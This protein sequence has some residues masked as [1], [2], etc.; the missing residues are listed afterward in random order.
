MQPVQNFVEAINQN[1][2]FAGALV[3]QVHL[4]TH[5]RCATKSMARLQGA[6]WTTKTMMMKGPEWGQQ[7]L[8][9]CQQ[10]CFHRF[11]ARLRD[12]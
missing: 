5:E 4:Q 2:E 8:H 3:S 1:V 6:V 7:H 11:H 9:P 12:V 10:S